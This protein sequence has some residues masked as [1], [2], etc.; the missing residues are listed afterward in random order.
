MQKKILFIL[1]GFIMAILFTACTRSADEGERDDRITVRLAA[2]QNALIEDFDTNEYK[3]WLEEETGLKLEMVWLPE[4]DAEQMVILALATGEDLPDAYIGFG[5]H[6]IFK[7]PNLQT[8]I[9]SGAIISLTDYIEEYGVNTKKTYELLDAFY[10]QELMTQSDGNIYFMPGF[11]YSMI[12][13]YSQ[14]LWLNQGWLDAL[15]LSRPTTT[16][17]LYEVLV[18]FRDKDPNGNGIQDE[19]PLCGT[20]AAYSKQ[21]YD[22]LMNAFIY[23]DPKNSRLYVENGEV[24]F[25]PITDAWREGLI[26]LNRLC[27]EG[28]LSPLSFTQ[29][30]QQMIQMANDS[31]DILGGFT[32]SGFTY[33]VNQSSPEVIARYQAVAPLAGPEGVQY[34][35][36]SF[37]L[38]KP[39][40]VITS[41]CEHP[42]EVF[43]LFDLMVSEEA[44]TKRL[45][46]QGVDWD[47]AKEG[48]LSIANKP[49]DIRIVNQ[50]WKAK[51]NKH[52][53]ELEPYVQSPYVEK[54]I[55]D[56]N[57]T[58]GEVINMQARFLYEPYEP[59]DRVLTLIFQPEEM[60]ELYEIRGSIDTHIKSGFE[61]FIT[62]KKDIHNDAV[63]KAYKAE[64]Y[65]IGLEKFLT[66]AQKS[67]E[68]LK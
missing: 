56:E 10:V 19:I 32:V 11:S 38:P 65:E 30:D 64:F 42:E 46:T 67:Y 31:R 44:A 66:A 28:L 58:D 55:V 43:K 29:S 48:E 37:P 9:D 22:N 50:L 63:W 52:L 14:I 4:K 68:Q 35:T 53:M 17:E 60:V 5:S 45:G 26:Y 15:G 36:L 39:N 25:A 8:Y 3:L 57:G 59:E 1:T 54:S 16:E 27:T 12:T 40:G 21:V 49:A 41:A 18:A 7:Q 13:R 23:N 62:G 20:E 34:C 2:P 51:Q 6:N 61:D 24:L 33:T 47:Y